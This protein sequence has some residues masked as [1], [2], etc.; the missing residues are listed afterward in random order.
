LLLSEARVF[1][2]APARLLRPLLA[3]GLSIEQGAKARKRFDRT[4]L[5][6]GVSRDMFRACFR[7]WDLGSTMTCD[8]LYS[9]D[10]TIWV[11]KGYLDA[12]R[13]SGEIGWGKRLTE[14]LET[15][16]CP[17]RAW[18]TAAYAARSF[19][20]PSLVRCSGRLD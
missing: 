9:R 7:K 16:S 11:A 4:L 17:R 3:P 8:T 10:G 13:Q 18:V 19:H 5:C 14:R 20:R 2:G 6:I 1:N 15:N 12:H